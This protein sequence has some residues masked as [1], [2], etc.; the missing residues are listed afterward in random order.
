MSQNASK[1]PMLYV[2]HK[3]WMNMLALKNFFKEYSLM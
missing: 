1:L 3:V 2:I